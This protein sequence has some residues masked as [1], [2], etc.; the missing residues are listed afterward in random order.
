MND[1]TER[2]DCKRCQ[3]ETPVRC[4]YFNSDY[5][6]QAKMSNHSDVGLC[7]ESDFYLKPGACVYYRVENSQTDDMEPK[8]CRCLAYR[9]M[10]LA[11]VKWCHEKSRGGAALY[12]AGLKYYHAPY[13]TGEC[14]EK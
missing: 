14:V 7:L 9:T 6:Y 13:E 11:E 12:E 2:R 10:A 5:Y 4:G 8:C 1:S 3:F